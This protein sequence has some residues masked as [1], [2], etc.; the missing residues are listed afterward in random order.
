MAD[1]VEQREEV[2]YG[3]KAQGALAEFAMRDDFSPQDGLSGRRVEF[4]PVANAHFFAGANEGVPVPFRVGVREEN[5]DQAG[6]L[7]LATRSRAASVKTRGDDAAVVENEQVAGVEKRRKVREGP[8]FEM[9]RGG[10]VVAVTIQHQHAAGA[11]HS[12]W[13]LGY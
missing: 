3:R 12:W 11:A 2:R 6:R 13:L 1:G 4:E 7:L 5:F 10:R 9:R 8:I